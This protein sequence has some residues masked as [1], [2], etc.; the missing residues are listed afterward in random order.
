[1]ADSAGDPADD[2][3]VGADP[4]VGVAC[5]L[6]VIVNVGAVDPAA[7]A[8]NKCAASDPPA[9]LSLIQQRLVCLEADH[10]D[11]PRYVRATGSARG[12]PG[13]LG[14]PASGRGGQP[15]AAAA[16]SKAGRVKRGASV[17]RSGEPAG[18]SEATGVGVLDRDLDAET[19]AATA[20]SAGGS[21]L[22]VL[23]SAPS[24]PGSAP[25]GAGSS[26]SAAAGSSPSAAA[27]DP[28]GSPAPIVPVAPVVRSTRRSGARPA[29][30]RPGP[31][32]VAVGILV[33][34]LVVALAFT[35]YRGGLTLPG[36]L[37]GAESAA[38]SSIPSQAVIQSPTPTATP[39]P[40]PSP[41]P[42]TSSTPSPTGTP[43]PSVPPAFVG[44]KPCP[45]APNCYLYRVRSG[46]TLTG[47]AQHFGVTKAAIQS[48]NPEITNPSLIHV[49]DMIR[50]PLQPG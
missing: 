27:G 14:R 35:S 48:L 1:V 45:D 28:S 33:A 2:A 25:S 12:G 4:F 6:L 16:V 5:P 40:T 44:L 49:G 46:D 39:T 32:V 31:I 13:R 18:S 30:S 8:D 3:R 37:P 19:A 42:S 41:A 17:A 15:V 43:Q 26:P 7:R 22:S 11:C 10:V 38:L 34:A 47:I 20:L 21:A 29:R 50:I 23:P 9:P 36:A 24:A